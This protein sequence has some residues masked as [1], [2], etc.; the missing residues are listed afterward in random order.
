VGPFALGT[1][2]KSKIAATGGEFRCDRY[3]VY[4][5]S[6]SSGVSLSAFR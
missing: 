4:R 3:K 2:Y 1:K 6:V 5:G